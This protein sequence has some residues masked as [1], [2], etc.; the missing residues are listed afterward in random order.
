MRYVFESERWET[1]FLL[2]EVLPKG[3]VEYVNPLGLENVESKCDV[4]VFSCRLHDFLNIKNVIQ[5]INPKVIIMLS[6]EFHQENKSIYN[7][8]E[9]KILI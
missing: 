3:N 4:F 2:N 9:N 1:N 8:R 5:K 7:Q 6:D